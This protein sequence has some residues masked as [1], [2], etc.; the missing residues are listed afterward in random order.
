MGMFD[1]Y[2]NLDPDYIPNN[3]HRCI[4]CKQ[5]NIVAGGSSFL[6]FELPKF[7]N[8]GLQKVTIIF[9]QEQRL[10]MLKEPTSVVVD[11]HFLFIECNLNSTESLQFGDTN[12]DTLVQLKLEYSDRILYT[13]I[14]KINIIPTL[15]IDESILISVDTGEN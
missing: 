9:N 11:E 12:L 6:L 7:Y 4:P 8:E 1:D 3:K 10:T 14:E 15:E 5:N 2:K 13:E